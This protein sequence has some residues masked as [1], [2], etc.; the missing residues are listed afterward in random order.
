MLVAKR[1]LRTTNTLKLNLGETNT[2]EVTFDN[3][4]AK[5]YSVKNNGILQVKNNLNLSTSVDLAKDSNTS[6]HVMGVN[7]IINLQN[8]ANLFLAPN[9]QNIENKVVL[10]NYRYKKTSVLELPKNTSKSLYIGQKLK[11]Y[12]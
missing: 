3:V 12:M 11:L 10:I 2:D 4:T 5:V 7:G 9:V 8:N 1:K 6:A